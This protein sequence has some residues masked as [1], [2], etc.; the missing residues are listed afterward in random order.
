MDIESFKIAFRD[1]LG[2]NKVTCHCGKV[3]YNPD[4]YWDWDDGELESLNLD[5]SAKAL[6]YTAEYISFEGLTYAI[7]C[8][9]WHS[10]AEH[11]M[12]FLDGHRSKVASYFSEE[13]KRLVADGESFP[14]IEPDSSR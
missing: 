3:C 13:R 4:E 12:R 8:D 7:D 1:G 11:I 9:C 2:G 10:R 6:D 5:E 14:V